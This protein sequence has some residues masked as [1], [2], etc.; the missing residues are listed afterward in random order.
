MKEPK[1]IYFE[2]NYAFNG[3]MRYE[4]SDQ[5]THWRPDTTYTSQVNSWPAFAGGDGNLRG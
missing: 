2:T 5:T 3:A 4:Q 1:G